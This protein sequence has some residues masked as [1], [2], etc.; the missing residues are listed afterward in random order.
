MIKRIKKH[1]DGE[2]FNIQEY[3]QT[4]TLDSICGKLNLKNFI[5]NALVP[6][7]KKIHMLTN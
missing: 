1:L 7:K 5:I 6:P 2:E 4:T 3:T